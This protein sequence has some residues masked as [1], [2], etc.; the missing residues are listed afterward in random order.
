MA[1]HHAYEIAAE[2]S[3][4]ARRSLAR[5]DAA[6]LLLDPAKAITASHLR[7][8]LAAHWPGITEPSHD[9]AAS[10]RQ[11]RNSAL[12]AIMA[13][14]LAGLSDLSENLSAIS[15][16][17]EQTIQLAYAVAAQGLQRG[18]AHH[19]TSTDSPSTC[20]LL[21]WESSGGRAQC[22]LRCRPHLPHSRGRSDHRPA[23]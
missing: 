19:K 6:G 12:L 21:E 13:R 20:S 17:A 16:L 10:L 14:D 23:P 3:G 8:H 4:F 5:L 1:L 9:A 22:L 7:E 15:A 2:H 18:T 11:F